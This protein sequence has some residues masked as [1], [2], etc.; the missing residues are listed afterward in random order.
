MKKIIAG[1]IAGAA[2]LA[3]VLP[4]L[5]HG[6]NLKKP[7]YFVEPEDKNCMGQLARMHAQD[8]KQGTNGLP[9]SFKKSKHGGFGLVLD[10]SV[11]ET[12]KA[13]KTYCG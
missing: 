8:E 12:M 3:S 10:S 4:A 9:A 13:F 6:A 7:E 11:H 2:L 1:A 5:A